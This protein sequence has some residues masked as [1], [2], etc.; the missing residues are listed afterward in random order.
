LP[1]LLLPDPCVFIVYLPVPPVLP[2][3]GISAG[4]YG[5]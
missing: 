1:L 2:K 4:P 5:P 3:P